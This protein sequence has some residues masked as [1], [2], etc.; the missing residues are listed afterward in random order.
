MG[1]L[2]AF[3][4]EIGNCLCFIKWP[5][6][7]YRAERYYNTNKNLVTYINGVEAI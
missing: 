2:T 7:N 5:E 1:K 6:N 3:L 4:T